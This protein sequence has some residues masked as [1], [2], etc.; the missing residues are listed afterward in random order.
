MKK[1]MKAALCILSAITMVSAGAVQAAAGTLSKEELIE[2]YAPNGAYDVS[3]IHL[4]PFT[5][6]THY[7]NDDTMLDITGYVQTLMDSFDSDNMTDEEMNQYSAEITAKVKD[8]FSSQVKKSVLY[9][10]EYRTGCNGKQMF[11][12]CSYA[13]GFYYILRENGTISIVG[14]DDD[15]FN[16]KTVMEIPSEIDGAVVTEIADRAFEY[17]AYY[18]PDLRKIILPDTVEIIGEGAFARAM[19]AA[20]SKINLPANLKVINR[21]AF[22]DSAQCLADKFYVIHLP[23]SIEYIGMRAM[24]NFL[25]DSISTA[26]NEFAHLTG[27][28]RGFV[29]CILD[30]PESCVMIE[31]D[32]VVNDAIYFDTLKNQTYAA[33]NNRNPDDVN[34]ILEAIITAYTNNIMMNQN[35]EK[36]E[37][38]V[39]Q[40]TPEAVNQFR[41][42]LLNADVPFTDSDIQIINDT[43]ND[44]FALLMTIYGNNVCGCNNVQEFCQAYDMTKQSIIPQYSFG[45][46]GCCIFLYDE[47]NYIDMNDVSAYYSQS[48][49]KPAE[50]TTFAGDVDNSG[51]VDVSDAVLLARFCAEEQTV[52]MTAAGRA[53]ADVNSDG[54]VTNEDVVAIEK[55]IAKL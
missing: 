51:T 4:A 42:E 49:P 2:K 14:A 25:V 24:T 32:K 3:S 34:A 30:M 11:K 20:D 33:V 39:I 9:Y 6:P 22:F 40:V 12:N 8:F 10:N 41:E 53:N 50:I 44:P 36:D 7:S 52:T 27:F 1:A 54:L 21:F 15:W 43:D 48:E 46:R 47:G 45:D 29:T 38:G 31:D 55:I 26:D 35:L 18:L 37:N 5:A 13:N 28:K 17:I 23:E 19:T 16:S